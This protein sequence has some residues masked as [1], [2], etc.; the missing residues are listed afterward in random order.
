VL[1]A[2][3]VP[4]LP[5][6]A[7]LEASVAVD[8]KRLAQMQNPDGGFALWQRGGASWPYVT[9]YVV[10]ALVTAKA[11]GFDVPA[12]LIERATPYLRDIEHRMPDYPRDVQRAIAAFALYVRKQAG[13]LDVAKARAL[14]RDAGGPDKLPLEADG[15]LLATLAGAPGAK[16]ERDAIVRH[17]LTQVSETAGAASFTTRYSDGAH[18]L[19]ASDRRVD[20][21]M[22]DA[23]IQ[24]QPA[25]DL[26]P[27]LV[28]GLLAGRKGGRWLNTQEN[29]YAL[30]ALDRYFQ[31]YEQTAPSFVARV[32]LGADHAGDLAF[33]ARSTKRFQ[34]DVPMKDV[35]AHDQQALTIQ[36]DGAGRLYYRIGMRYAPAS[37]QLAPADDGFVVERSYEAADAPEDVTRDAQGVW[38]I[39]VGARVRVKLAMVNEH[40]RYHVALVDPL[41]AGLEPLNSSLATTGPIPTSKRRWS[42][43]WYEHQNMRDE[44]VEAFTPQ[45]YAGVHR[46][47]YTARA[48]TPGT[49]VVPPAKAEEMYMPE[50]F[51]RSGSD[52]VIVE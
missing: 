19:L 46:Y 35:A 43:T 17:A 18:L 40:R 16:P 28:T 34:I 49:F 3:E 29:T 48:T 38:P 36:K 25:H 30:V 47:E 37:L 33:F 41:P 39:K 6:R 13:D 22:L 12:E 1:E 21:V 32:W 24:D 45:L 27:K 20:A 14:L 5:T 11:K 8:V 23:L 42:A 51:G 7:E 44:R 26:I 50:T 10:S 15:W 52:R 2:F 31:T 9:A 4:A